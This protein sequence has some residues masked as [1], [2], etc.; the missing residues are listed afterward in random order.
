LL[1]QIIT[2]SASSIA[3]DAPSFLILSIYAIAIFPRLLT[4]ASSVCPA[5]SQGKAGVR[6]L[7]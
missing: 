7:P 4:S 2:I 5:T 1:P 3:Q 6:S